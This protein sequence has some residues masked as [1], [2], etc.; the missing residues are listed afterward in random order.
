VDVLE[1]E[2]RMIPA[3]PWATFWDH[4]DDRD[5]PFPPWE[6]PVAHAEHARALLA[7]ALHQDDERDEALNGA[8]PR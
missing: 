2:G 8:Q 4:P 7:A 6:I 1:H 5:E 3:D